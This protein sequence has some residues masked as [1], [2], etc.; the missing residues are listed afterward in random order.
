MSNPLQSL[1][2]RRTIET[3]TE[4]VV[5]LTA[6]AWC[7]WLIRRVLGAPTSG[8]E[9]SG[10][11]LA[12]LLGGIVAVAAWYASRQLY[13]LGRRRP[14][15]LV[16]A[17]LVLAGSVMA[18]L[19]Y[20]VPQRF[21]TSCAKLGGVLVTTEGLLGAGPARRCQIGGVPGNVYLPGTLLRPSW[22]GDVGLPLGVWLAAVTVLAS[23]GLRDQR[24]RPTRMGA[25]LSETLTL[26]PAAGLKAVWGPKPADAKIQACGNATLWGEPC[27]QLYA[28]E[29]PFEAGEWCVRCAQV[30]QPAE[31]TVR[32]KVVTLFTADVD[33]LNGLE[34]LDASAWDQGAPQPPDARLSGQERW[35]KLGTLEIPDVVTVA[36]ALAVVHDLLGGWKSKGDQRVADAATLAMQRAS[37]LTAWI[38]QGNHDHRLTYAR[39]TQRAHLAVG[40]ARLRDL[41]IQTGE[42]LVLQLDIGLLPLELRTGFR[43]TFLDQDR[44]P[45]VQNLKQDLWVPVAGRAREAKGAWVP[46]VEGEALRAW[47]ALDRLRR[48][49]ELGVSSPLPYCLPG[50]PGHGDGR[51]KPGSIDLVRMPLDDDGAEPVPVRRPGASIAEW[52]WAEWRLIEALRQEALVMVVR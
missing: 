3:V 40:P 4:L 24:L 50:T 16:I 14:W 23:L 17:S 20:A 15:T 48:S 21:D 13:L 6:L 30:Y 47:L 11:E 19:V 12:V 26:R 42:E 52:D 28:A 43:Q 5:P 33:V 49:D 51:V 8:R 27:A 29:K 18:S 41:A 9:L 10:L 44:A 31:R 32:L 34:R 46:R 36:T 35:V 38:W 22:S 37:R 45:V 25:H 39:P 7:W 1:G 2:A